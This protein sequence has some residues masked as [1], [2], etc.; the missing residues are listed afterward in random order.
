MEV[1]ELPDH[2]LKAS[3]QSQLEGVLKAWERGQGD[4]AQR[5]IDALRVSLWELQWRLQQPPRPVEPLDHEAAG[6]M[7]AEVLAK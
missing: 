6:R 1:R 5:G 7:L 2:L 4:V 3:L